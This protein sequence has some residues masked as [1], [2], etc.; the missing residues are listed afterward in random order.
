MVLT[1]MYN[2]NYERISN[3]FQMIV[4]LKEFGVNPKPHMLYLFKISKITRLSV[5]FINS[6][7]YKRRNMLNQRAIIN[8]KICPKLSILAEISFQEYNKRQNWKK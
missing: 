6:W 3:R 7:F 4:L 8:S 2:P 5:N 1:Q